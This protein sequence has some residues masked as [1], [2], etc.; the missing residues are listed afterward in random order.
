[1]GRAQNRT[2]AATSSGTSRHTNLSTATPGTANKP[3]GEMTAQELATAIN[4]RLRSLEADKDW[5]IATYGDRGTTRTLTRLFHSGARPGVGGRISVTYVTYQGSST[6]ERGQAEDYLTWL[7][8]GNRGTH[9][10]A[11]QR[12]AIRKSAR[13]VERDAQKVAYRTKNGFGEDVFSAVYVPDD[14]PLKLAAEGLQPGDKVW[15]QGA[16]RN[17]QDAQFYA[18]PEPEELHAAQEAARD[19]TLRGDYEELERQADKLGYLAR[20]LASGRELEVTVMLAGNKTL[21]LT[22]E[23][24]VGIKRPA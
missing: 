5:N 21:R 11:D 15:F 9:H 20:Q 18:P 17:V 2:A 16:W 22:P 14:A 6:L 4:N 23:A 1:M 10:E 3:V 7:R 13:L 24:Q 8:A 12:G 19:A